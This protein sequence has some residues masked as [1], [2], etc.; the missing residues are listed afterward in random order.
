MENRLT[1]TQFAHLADELH[2]ALL[3]SIP[4]GM[5]FIDLGGTVRFWNDAAEQISGFSIAEAVCSMHSGDVFSLNSSDGE[6]IDLLQFP[7]VT[8]ECAQPHTA[9][10][11]HKD[12]HHIPVVVRLIPVLTVSGEPFGVLYLFSASNGV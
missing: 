2:L 11:R 9:F 1:E 7:E 6:L 12:G 8:A 4:D 3:Q 5:C 10:L